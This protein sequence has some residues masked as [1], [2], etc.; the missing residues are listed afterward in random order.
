[1]FQTSFSL[2]EFVME[3]VSRIVIGSYVTVYGQD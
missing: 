2:L 3:K 1:M